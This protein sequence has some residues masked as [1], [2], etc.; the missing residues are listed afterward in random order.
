MALNKRNAAAD[1][2]AADTNKPSFEGMEDGGAVDT[3]VQTETVDQETGEVTTASAPAETGHTEPGSEADAAADTREAA[4]PSKEAVAKATETAVALSKQHA[5]ATGATKKFAAALKDKENVFDPSSL[6]FNTFPRVTV[7]LDGFSK[8]DGTDLGKEIALE[9]MSYN[10]RWVA[11]P[12]TDDEEAKKHV[13]YSLDG[14]TIDS[15]GDDNGDDIQEYIRTLKTVHGYTDAGLKQYLSIYGF[16]TSANGEAI[17]PADLE[18]VALQVPPQS[19]PLFERHQINQGVKISRGSVE[20]S[21][22]VWCQQEKKTGGNK[23]FAQINF[24]AKQVGA[25]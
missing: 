16:L 20:A 22:I 24:G 4:K 2:Q 11:S 6:D 14:K 18:I 23:K 17:D 3:A 15:T 25:K 9:V 19:R 10:T 8:D 21:D 13:R 12:G 1:T 7:G 5:V